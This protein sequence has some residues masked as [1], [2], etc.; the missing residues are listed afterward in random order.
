MYTSI[1]ESLKTNHPAVIVSVNMFSHNGATRQR[2]RARKANGK[3]E[4][5]IVKY[6]TGLFSSP[7]TL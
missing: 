2:I 6:E 1:E 3:K 7:V 5:L 4:Y